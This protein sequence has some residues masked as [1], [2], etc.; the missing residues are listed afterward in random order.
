VVGIGVVREAFLGPVFGVEAIK[1]IQ[2]GKQ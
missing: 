2:R 1:R